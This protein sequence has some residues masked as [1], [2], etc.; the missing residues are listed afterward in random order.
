[1]SAVESNDAW[2]DKMPSDWQRSRIRNVPRLSG[3]NCLTISSSSGR[4]TTAFW[5]TGCCSS[6]ANYAESANLTTQGLADFVFHIEIAERPPHCPDEN[7]ASRI[8][9]YT[10]VL[11]MVPLTFSAP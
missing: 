6:H 2:L 10:S 4:T 9:R 11:S 1:M 8:R 3:L 5:K 7:M